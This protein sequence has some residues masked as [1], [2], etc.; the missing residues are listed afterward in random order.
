MGYNADMEV[1]DKELQDSLYGLGNYHG[2]GAR[3]RNCM[4]MLFAWT[5]NLVPLRVIIR[6][7]R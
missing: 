6:P 1:L 3:L 5:R 4:G 2:K 7:Q